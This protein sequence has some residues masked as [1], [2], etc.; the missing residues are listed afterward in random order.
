MK[1]FFILLLLLIFI[2]FIIL[3]IG[4]SIGGYKDFEVLE[5]LNSDANLLKI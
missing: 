2:L 4:K 5:R 3:Y 1:L